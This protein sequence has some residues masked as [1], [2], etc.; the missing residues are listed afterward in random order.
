MIPDSAALHPGYAETVAWME[1]SGIRG[2]LT[3]TRELKNGHDEA[4]G[5]PIGQR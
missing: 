5:E 2:Q 1:R 4:R 3:K